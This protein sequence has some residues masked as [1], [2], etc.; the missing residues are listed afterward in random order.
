MSKKCQKW[1]NFHANK[2]F[3]GVQMILPRVIFT[4]ESGGNEMKIL[5]A[6]LRTS[7]NR[8]YYINFDKYYFIFLNYNELLL[9]KY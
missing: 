3:H 5:L 9:S 4:G 7:F 6:Y 1:R 2:G 8:K